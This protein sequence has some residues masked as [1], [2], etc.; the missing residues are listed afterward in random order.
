MYLHGIF[1]SVVLVMLLSLF[2][3]CATTPQTPQPDRWFGADKAKHFATSA[4]LAAAFVDTSNNRD[5]ENVIVSVSA[6]LVIGTGKEI[7]D[8]NIKRTYF[9]YKDMIWNFL[10]SSLGALAA[11]DC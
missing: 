4:A 3:G 8:K 2:Y 10:G 11:S 9:S 1:R 7:Y 5:C 6:V